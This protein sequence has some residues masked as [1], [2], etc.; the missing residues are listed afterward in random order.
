[1]TFFQA[2]RKA[3]GFFPYILFIYL[4][5]FLQ[6]PTIYKSLRLLVTMQLFRTLLRCSAVLGFCMGLAE[7]VNGAPGGS[8]NDAINLFPREI[9]PGGTLL[10]PYFTSKSLVQRDQ[11]PLLSSED[12]S[13]A[14][15]DIE[16]VQLP[17]AGQAIELFYGEG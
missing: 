1:M 6:L 13:A 15:S 4:F 3:F 8:K 11:I 16:A 17:E 9:T 10:I 2:Y 7:N 12:S 14:N 5:S